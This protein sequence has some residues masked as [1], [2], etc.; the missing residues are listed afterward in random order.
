VS[1]GNEQ[2]MT[3]VKIGVVGCAGRMGTTVVREVVATDGCV[4]S[5][6]TE[7]SGHE[8]LGRDLGEVAGCG[9][10]DLTVTDD[11]VA[12]FAGSDAIID[13]TTPKATVA[14]ADLAAQARAV[15]VIGTTGLDEA[16]EEELKK[17]AR[18]TVL[19]R[20]ANMSLGVN[21]LMAL[22]EQVARALDD[23]FD[24]E[25]V[26][27]HHRAKVDAPSG[28]ALGLG[29]A[30]AKGR[31]AELDDVAVR[32]R[33]GHTGA[34]PEGAIGFATLRGGDVVGDHTVIFAGDGERVELTHKAGSRRIYARGAVR[35]ALWAQGRPPGLYGMRDVLGLAT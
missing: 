17:A 30:A 1:E 4:L 8:A 19:V 26:E 9:P 34:R 25:I 12:L 24:V 6:A 31:G 14:H 7:R 32:A 20:A 5:G 3:D 28:T 22:V 35:A 18:H 13:F 11:P 23:S 27:M 21:L 2:G 15:H 29:R 16:Q 33:D 10:L